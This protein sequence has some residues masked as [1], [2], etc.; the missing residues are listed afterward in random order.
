[1][2]HGE[3]IVILQLLSVILV[4]QTEKIFLAIMYFLILPIRVIIS[5]SDEIMMAIAYTKNEPG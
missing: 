2:V 4:I 1:M 3:S 5:L